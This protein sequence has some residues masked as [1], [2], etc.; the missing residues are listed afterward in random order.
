M[1]SRSGSISDQADHQ[2]IIMGNMAS[3]E[4]MTACQVVRVL[5][6]KHLQMGVRVR[7]RQPSDTD[8]VACT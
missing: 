2:I 4:T 3:Y 1:G 5:L 6:Q 8:F 7:G